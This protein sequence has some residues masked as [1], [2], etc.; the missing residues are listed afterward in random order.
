MEYVVQFLVMF[1][2][3]WVAVYS[4]KA[5]IKIGVII[6][7]FLAIP[8]ILIALTLGGDGAFWTWAGAGFSFVT[9]GILK[10]ISASFEHAAIMTAGA[11]LGV[12]KGIGF[13]W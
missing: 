10:A 13:K 9:I 3:G 2:L 1:A 8:L 7:G 11:F 12:L 5:W 4:L 6:L